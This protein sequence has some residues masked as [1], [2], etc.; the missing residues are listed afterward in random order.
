L[1]VSGKKSRPGFGGL[2]GD[3]GGEHGGLAVGG[4]D[5]AVRLAGDAPGLQHEPAP[6][7]VD[8][9]ALD[10]EHLSCIR[11]SEDAKARGAC[12]PLFP[13]FVIGKTAGGWTSSAP[14]PRRLLP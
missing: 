3:D 9:F 12:R 14:G 5:G 13:G 11:K 6:A 10:I 7:P 1:T 8:F 2:G 4:D